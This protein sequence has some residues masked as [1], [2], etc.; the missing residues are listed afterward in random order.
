M[1][2]PV[3]EE[4]IVK[5]EVTTTEEEVMAKTVTKTAKLERRKSRDDI[6]F[7]SGW[8]RTVKLSDLIRSNLIQEQTIIELESE[9][10]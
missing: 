10:V 4:T 1:A 5:S 6:T 9:E 7:R 8:R 2:T 3:V